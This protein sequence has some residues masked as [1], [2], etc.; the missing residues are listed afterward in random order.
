MLI[1]PAAGF[2]QAL[3][4]SGEVFRA[5]RSHCFR[6]IGN[7]QRGI[8]LPQPCASFLCLLHMPG[9]RIAYGSDTQDCLIVRS[10][11]FRERGRQCRHSTSAQPIHGCLPG[12]WA[13]ARAL[14]R[15]RD[16]LVCE[17]QC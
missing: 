4:V 2:S 10:F 3:F 15:E 6:E 5:E 8:E 17:M 16:L 1:T 7:A 12:Q 14:T 13:K 11:L 9:K